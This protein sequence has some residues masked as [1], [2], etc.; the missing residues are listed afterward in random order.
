MMVVTIF[1]GIRY[2]VN[3]HP[4]NVIKRLCVELHQKFYWWFMMLL[5]CDVEN[6]KIS[7][8]KFRKIDNF[9]MTFSRA[10]ENEKL[11]AMSAKNPKIS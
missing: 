10:L 6:M 8:L 5:V 4:T 7:T 2:V 11:E 3:K 1:K 9:S